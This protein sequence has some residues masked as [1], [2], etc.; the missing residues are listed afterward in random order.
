MRKDNLVQK[1]MELEKDFRKNGI[2]CRVDNGSSAIGKRYART[3]EMG[4]PFAVTV[5]YETLDKDT[6]TLRDIKSMKQIRV[7]VAELRGLIQG[8]IDNESDFDQLAKNY[9]LFENTENA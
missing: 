5:D 7:P 1:V 4:I 3:D 2:M 8:A 6:V 9:P